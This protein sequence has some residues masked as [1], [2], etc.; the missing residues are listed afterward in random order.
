MHM[1]AKGNVKKSASAGGLYSSEAGIYLEFS[2]FLECKPRYNG[3]YD[4]YIGKF[5]ATIGRDALIFLDE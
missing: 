2:N 4:F 1:N 3:W 5:P